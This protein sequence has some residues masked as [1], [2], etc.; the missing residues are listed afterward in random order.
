ML[1]ES[2]LPNWHAIKTYSGA[3]YPMHSRAVVP[4][5]SVYLTWIGMRNYS[6]VKLRLKVIGEHTS[7]LAC[8]YNMQCCHQPYA[9]KC[10]CAK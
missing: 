2:K 1:A 3:I 10:S 4:S 6:L 5:E 9:F 7:K 8:N